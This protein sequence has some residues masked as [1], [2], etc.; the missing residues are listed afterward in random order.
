MVHDAA[1]RSLL[2]LIATGTSNT[3]YDRVNPMVQTGAPIS[4]GTLSDIPRHCVILSFALRLKDHN[5]DAAAAFL[6]AGFDP[7]VGNTWGT[8]LQTAT[9]RGDV[10]CAQWLLDNG[11]HPDLGEHSATVSYE[12]H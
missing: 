11:A 5:F 4:L 7:N 3:T 6:A 12:V 2:D 10:T 9:A 1:A 8:P